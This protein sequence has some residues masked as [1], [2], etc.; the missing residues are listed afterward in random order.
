[1]PRRSTQATGRAGEHYVAAELNR[2][3]V[4]ASPFSGNVP[5]IDIVATSVD[6]ERMALIQVKTKRPKSNWQVMLNKGW[7]EI[8]PY[9]CPEDGSCGD[10]C[11][12]KL[13][14]PITGKENHYW[15]FVSLQK[16]GGQH[17]FIVPD[18][19]VRRHLVREKHLAYLDKNGGQRPGK[20]HDSIHHSFKDEGL[21]PWKDKWDTL[22]LW[23]ASE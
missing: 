19:D 8:L 6:G 23:S 16:D 12:P 11:T 2:R 3:E 4:Y 14:V 17:Y 22:G 13:G 21:Q 18:D 20:K 15:V 10:E 7:S 5:D 9:G 1:M